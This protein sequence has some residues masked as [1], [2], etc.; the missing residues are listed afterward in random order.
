MIR[1]TETIC[2]KQWQALIL[3]GASGFAFGTV[4]STAVSALGL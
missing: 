3:L 1:L 4:L 2:I